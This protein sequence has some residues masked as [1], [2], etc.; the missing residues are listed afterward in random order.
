M[1]ILIKFIE[2]IVHN[3]NNAHVRRQV[4]ACIHALTNCLQAYVLR[5]GNE[6]STVLSRDRKI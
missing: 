1:F 2:F 4:M 5:K 6:R 3:A